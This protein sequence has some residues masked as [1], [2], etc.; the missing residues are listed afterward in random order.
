MIDQ[1]RD[2][3]CPRCGGEWWGT[4]NPL[5]PPEQWEGRCTLC[6][7]TWPRS[8]DEKHFRPSE[9]A[10]DRA[11]ARLVRARTDAAS[12][13]IFAGPESVVAEE[14]AARQALRDLGV[15]VDALLGAP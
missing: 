6:G 2:F 4:T 13:A 14:A 10:R 7:F 1:G 15:D 3:C 5:D 11:W 9:D 12:R 8:E